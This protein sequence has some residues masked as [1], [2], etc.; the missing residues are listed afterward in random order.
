MPSSFRN[1]KHYFRDTFFPLPD[2]PGKLVGLA[3]V[4]AM[5]ALGSESSAEDKEDKEDNEDTDSVPSRGRLQLAML[6]GRERYG[7]EEKAVFLSLSVVT[8]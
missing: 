1:W 6:V 4:G 7:N 2:L 8:M 5:G 3:G